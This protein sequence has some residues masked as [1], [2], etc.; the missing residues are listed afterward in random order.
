MTIRPTER[1]THWAMDNL[2]IP[3]AYMLARPAMIQGEKTHPVAHKAAV[4][5]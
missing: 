3:K 4:N 1:N 5:A 2:L